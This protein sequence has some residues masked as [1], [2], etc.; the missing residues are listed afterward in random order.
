MDIILLLR[1]LLK[2][3][4]HKLVFQ[5]N[6]DDVLESDFDPRPVRRKK[7]EYQLPNRK[8]KS[9]GKQPR[10][11]DT[12]AWVEPKEIETVSNEIDQTTIN[13]VTEKNDISDNEQ[14]FVQ[15]QEDN[16]ER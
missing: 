12:G 9:R 3:F 11:L 1:L 5:P 4:N 16:Q 7:L 10:N 2:T 14:A 6:Y 13:D 15:Y 8:Y